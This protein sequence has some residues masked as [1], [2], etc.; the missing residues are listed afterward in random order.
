MRRAAKVDANHNAIRKAFED[1]GIWCYST[2]QLGAGF[3]DLM[4][5]RAVPGVGPKTA[6]IE[7]KDGSKPPS[8]R[9]LTP[10]QLEFHARYPGACFVVTSV[11]DVVRVVQQFFS[12]GATNGRRLDQG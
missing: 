8:A 3:P 2:A 10:Q 6:L 7:I 12:A 5:S 1:A 4:V 11:D 9:M